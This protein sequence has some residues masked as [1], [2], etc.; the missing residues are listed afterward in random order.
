MTCRGHA[1]ELEQFAQDHQDILQV[2]G[3]GSQERFVDAEDFLSD[4][5]LTTL[6]L[7]WEGSGALWR[8]NEIGRN[9]AV[10]LATF[11]LSDL[12]REFSFNDAGRT[13]A[14]DAAP[15]PPWGP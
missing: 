14:L 9:S 10:Q 3:V 4:T 5:G 13:T 15:Q 6:P 1:A 12:S 8:L 11:D 7:L 2:V